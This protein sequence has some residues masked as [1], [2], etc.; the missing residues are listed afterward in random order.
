[1]GESRSDEKIHKEQSKLGL[2]YEQSN[3]G[4]MN[5]YEG[6]MGKEGSRRILGV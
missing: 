4:F 3:A 5:M 1:M 2:K 6:G